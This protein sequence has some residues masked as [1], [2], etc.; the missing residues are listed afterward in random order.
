MKKSEVLRTLFDDGG[1]LLD[2]LDWAWR[3]SRETPQTPQTTEEILNWMDRAGKKAEKIL[4]GLGELK[5]E[6]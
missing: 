2:A 6:K 1:D 3:I 5:N 4:K